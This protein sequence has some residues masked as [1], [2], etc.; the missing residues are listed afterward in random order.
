M[1][2]APR[3]TE[4]NCFFRNAR[5]GF[6]AAAQKKGKQS[7]WIQPGAISIR[8]DFAGPA[9]LPNVLPALVHL[10]T[11]PLANASLNIEI[12]DSASTGITMPPPP[13][14]SR[15]YI[16]RNEIRNFHG[17]QSITVAYN[18]GSSML[19]MLKTDSGM[20]IL[21]MQDAN[22]CPY[23]E[24]AA[25]LRTL[26]HW[27]C[28][29]LGKQL[30]HGAAVGTRKGALLLAGRGGSGKST[31]ALCAV[32]AG[33]DYL[34]DDYVLCDAT[35]S[36]VSVHSLF[37]T[38]KLDAIA[39][40][41][42][43]ELS[44]KLTDIEVPENEK[45]VISIAAHFPDRISRSRQLHALIIPRVTNQPDSRLQRIRPAQAFLALAPTTIFQLPGANAAS[46]A[47]LKNLIER[48]PCYQLDVGNDREQTVKLLHELIGRHS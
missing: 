24:K 28:L 36:T 3:A 21:W 40:Q 19:S 26:L 4:I 22:N 7:V 27:W 48:L 32:L 35:E 20:G 23:W 11:D 13:W 8:L 2:A 39:L 18:P 14:S 15:D 38:A 30:V 37:N 41:R 34:G 12:W 33:M 6:Q 1:D 16:A 31:T 9:M 17:S 29:G 25:P 45:A 42:I 46:L 47:F 5:S 44:S 43:P 10:R